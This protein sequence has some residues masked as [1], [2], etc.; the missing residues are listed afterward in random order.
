[1]AGPRRAAGSRPGDL[2]AGRREPAD[3]R[4]RGAPSRLILDVPAG[5]PRDAPAGS[6]VARTHHLVTA[7]SGPCPTA[8]PPDCPGPPDHG[9]MRAR[10]PRGIHSKPVHREAVGI[11]LTRG[12]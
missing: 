6:G 7:P 8:T 10:Y 4:P 3:P 12:P 9:A 2:P 1:M 11:H 5:R